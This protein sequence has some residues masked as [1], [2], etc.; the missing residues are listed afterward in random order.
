MDK[1]SYIVMVDS[2]RTILSML[3]RVLN[4]K[5]CEDPD[6]AG[7]RKALSLLKESAPN[8]VF[9]DMAMPELDESQANER[10]LQGLSMPVLLISAKCEL[11]T[12][13]DTRILGISNAQSEEEPS[14][15]GSNRM[16]IKI[17]EEQ[18]KIPQGPFCPN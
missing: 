16:L 9:L 11:T 12:L 14:I 18:E 1:H 13:D 2:E 10:M 5:D 4:L 6:T 15:N 17:K 7:I 3:N 8:L